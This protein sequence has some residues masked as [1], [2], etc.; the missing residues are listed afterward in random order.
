MK[1]KIKPYLKSLIKVNLGYIILM[2][3]SFVLILAIIR[4]YYEQ[5][6]SDEMK[7]KSLNQDLTKL[8][9]KANLLNSNIPLS[10]DLDQDIKF[11]NSLIPNVED[12]FSIIYTLEN[13]SQKTGFLVTSYTVNVEQSTSDRLKLSVSGVGDSD[14]FLNFL[15]QYNFGG[16]RLITSDK[17]ELNSQIS[18]VIKIDL[19]FYNKSAAGSENLT[20]PSDNKMFTEIEALKKK[21]NFD[22]NEGLT[23]ENPDLNYPKKANPF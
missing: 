14:S 17:I 5:N 18:G 21:V 23:Q 13:L 4:I 10:E 9:S 1:I 7:I 11:L 8:Q 15:N 19:T 20:L 3:L 6:L 2:L 16:G 22:I 12:Y